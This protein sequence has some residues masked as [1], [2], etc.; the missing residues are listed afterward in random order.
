MS[1]DQEHSLALSREW[2]EALATVTALREDTNE[3]H[4][5]VDALRSHVDAL[6][7]HADA[8]WHELAEVRRNFADQKAQVAE[9]RRYWAD[10]KTIVAECTVVR[11]ALRVLE[12]FAVLEATGT[13]ELAKKVLYVSILETRGMSPPVWWT[14]EIDTLSQY[15]REQGFHAPFVP[16]TKGELEEALKSPEDDDEDRD[17]QRRIISKLEERYLDIGQEFGSSFRIK[18]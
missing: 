10:Q 11:R 17:V 14:P 4:K 18:G 15:Y 16:F 12:A 6:R 8:R 3:M 5:E 1:Q 2:E 9:L 13:T 7:S